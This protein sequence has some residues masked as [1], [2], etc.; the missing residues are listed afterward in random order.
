MSITDV[1]RGHPYWILV[2]GGSNYEV[3]GHFL[4]LK[5]ARTW[6]F[7]HM[8]SLGGGEFLIT[9]T[10]YIINCENLKANEPSK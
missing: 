3:R 10:A 9:E 4:T 2:T 7:D 6:A 1:A 8:D 5:E